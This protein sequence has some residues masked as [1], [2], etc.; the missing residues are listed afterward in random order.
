MIARGKPDR[1]LGVLG[2]AELRGL[3]VDP[4]R[5]CGRGGKTL[6]DRQRPVG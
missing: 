4:Y 5:E 6:Q 3:D 2:R 1:A